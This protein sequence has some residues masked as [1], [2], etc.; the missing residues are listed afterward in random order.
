MLIGI[1]GKQGTGKTTLADH[2]AAQLKGVRVSF[3]DELRI[4]VEENFGVDMAAMRDSSMKASMLLPVGNRYFKLRELM[5]WWGAQRREADPDYW[6][7]K[8][9]GR[10]AQNESLTVVDDV[11]YVNEAVAIHKAGGLLIRL[12]PYSGWQS[13]P[14]ADHASET[15]L[16]DYGYFDY[17]FSPKFGGLF[18]L[19]Y[20]IRKNL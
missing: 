18:P 6:I 9:I 12:E 20:E 10:T 4:E 1:S 2:L 5:Q 8:L 15:E 17:Q 3:A 19:V 11:R 13:G 7:R 16:D 14:G